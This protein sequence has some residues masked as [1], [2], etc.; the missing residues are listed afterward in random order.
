MTRKPLTLE[1]R[2][3]EISNRTLH[4]V[5]PNGAGTEPVYFVKVPGK[6][7]VYELRRRLTELGLRRHSL[8]DKLRVVR[9][10]LLVTVEDGET[11]I[12]EVVDPYEQQILETL[13]WQLPI[14]R[15]LAEAS[16]ADAPAIMAELT[17]EGAPRVDPQLDAEMAE[18]FETMLRHSARYRAL[19]ADDQAW[20][21]ARPYVVAQHFLAGWQG[22]DLPFA[23]IG[24]HVA[25]T[26]LDK[27]P[28]AHLAMIANHVDALISPSEEQEKNSASPSAS[29]SV[30]RPSPAARKRRTAA[31]AGR[32]AAKSS[33]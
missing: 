21:E 18:V 3:P 27:I 13:R 23:I 33:R 12:A 5:R 8:S 30:P 11:W 22:I 7:D 10:E 6:L 24:D 19:V 28:D 9:K 26:A 20:A 16:E 17:A 15:R 2:P 32:S 25:A 1:A 29:S 14:W 4:E 31:K